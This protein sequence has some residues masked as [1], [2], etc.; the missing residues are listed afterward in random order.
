MNVH[1]ALMQSAE[2]LPESSTD[3]SATD[4]VHVQSGPR[5]ASLWSA[6]AYP[7]LV[8]QSQSLLINEKQLQL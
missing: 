6:L 3:S 1:C 4:Q 7:H 2:V 5:G 8:H